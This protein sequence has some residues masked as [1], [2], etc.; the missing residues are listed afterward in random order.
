MVLDLLEQ[1]STFPIYKITQMFKSQ[2][3]GA[4]YTALLP[5]VIIVVIF[6][7]SMLILSFLI[8][9]DPSAVYVC[10]TTEL[11]ISLSSFT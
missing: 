1:T 3:F 5:L 2:K 9:T 6:D 11:V 4:S 10:V 8:V 7:A